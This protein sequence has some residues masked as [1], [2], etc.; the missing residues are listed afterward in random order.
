MRHN[1][2]YFYLIL[3]SLLILLSACGS[4]EDSEAVFVENI[5]TPATT[6]TPEPSATP[7]PPTATRAI[8]GTPL[9]TFT[10]VASISAKPKA[11]NSESSP[12]S[13]PS[14]SPVPP[15][16]PLAA[17]AL[18]MPLACAGSFGFGLSCLDDHGWQSY[19]ENN[20]PLRNNLVSALALCPEGYFLVA[21]TSHLY[22]FDGQNWQ[23]YQSTWGSGSVS[24]LF[25]E[26]NG[27]IWAT[28]FK[29]VSYFDGQV[30]QTYSAENFGHSDGTYDL[31]KAI[32]RAPSGDIWVA[33]ANSLARFDGQTWQAFDE[34]SLGD[35]YFFD[36][37][38]FD[39]QG[40]LWAVHSTGLLQYDQQ[41]WIE[42][43]LPEWFSPN[44]GVFDQA[45]HIW[46]GSYSG[47]YRYTIADGTWHHI[48]QDDQNLSSN[49]I[50]ALFVDEANRLWT[51]TDWGLSIAAQDLWQVYHMHTAPLVDNDIR[52]VVVNGLG[53][54]LPEPQAQGFGILSGQLKADG[55]LFGGRVLSNVPLE[56]CTARPQRYINDE[57]PCHDQALYFSLQSDDQGYFE[58]SNIPEGRY[59]ITAAA[60]D[61]WL[62]WYAETTLLAQ[63][64][65]QAGQELDLGELHLR[66]EP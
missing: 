49:T 60:G 12:E 44:Q 13:D 59:Y 7:G 6:F 40:H 46:L 18:N 8:R 53:P 14:P 58:H 20:S 52:H 4:D 48:T 26:E 16:T 50:Q 3:A 42:I 38:L 35:L 66:L 22:A 21:T 43:S 28:H 15:V 45:G 9:P 11:S 23:S 17:Q 54:I 62:Y 61:T 5:A 34:E 39:G 19:T 31:V 27:H 57:S 29:G 10:T 47:L 32:D 51:G 36:D 64:F 55:G 24:D 56:I 41:Q 25:C 1:P 30:W 2:K 65:V 33:T 37:L 63:V